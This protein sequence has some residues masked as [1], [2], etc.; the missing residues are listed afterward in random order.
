L[1]LTHFYDVRDVA[2]ATCTSRRVLSCVF[3][4]NRNPHSA[5]NMSSLFL[6]QY[7]I[8][9]ALSSCT[10]IFHVCL[11]YL[12]KQMSCLKSPPLPP[13]PLDPSAAASA[14]PEVSGKGNR[15]AKG[16][17]KRLAF[18]LSC[19][20]FFCLVL[21]CLVL[22]LLVLSS[23]PCLKS[24]PTSLDPLCSSQCSARSQRERHQSGQSRFEKGMI[25]SFLVFV[26]VLVLS[27][28]LPWSGSW[29]WYWSWAWS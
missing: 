27:L 25:L 24:P 29:S 26:F 10:S 19:L 21:S 2:L 17:L 1:L 28:S 18:V 12:S 4:I 9:T 3:L 6:P 16:V 7:V 13:R 11:V 15:G 22:A 14:A 23:L 5:S 8:L 20:V